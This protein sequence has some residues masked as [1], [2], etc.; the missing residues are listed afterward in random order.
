MIL[1][2]ALLELS[3]VQ[4]ETSDAFILMASQ[5]EV[6]NSDAD[7]NSG[8]EETD[9]FQEVA[10]WNLGQDTN[11]PPDWDFSDSLS[12]APMKFWDKITN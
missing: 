1:Y 5:F 12:E 2:Y 7:N 9:L 4:F 10:G 11:H 6:S 8:S 3:Y